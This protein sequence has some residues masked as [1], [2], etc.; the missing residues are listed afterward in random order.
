MIIFKLNFSLKKLI[1]SSFSKKNFQVFKL[2]QTLVSFFFIFPVFLIFLLFLKGHEPN[3]LF[4]L[5]LEKKLGID[6]ISIF[7]KI[8]I[9]RFKG[10]VY[11]LPPG[12]FVLGNVPDYLRHESNFLV[13]ESERSE[14]CLAKV[15]KRKNHPE[16]QCCAK[17]KK[18][19]TEIYCGKHKNC[20]SF[21][22]V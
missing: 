4:D 20:H 19:Q 8:Q 18:N 2:Q 3:L 12:A 11:F 10:P 1:F 7:V 17:I 13:K 22:W 6:K 5:S 16:H 21:R 14:I 15:P 9:L